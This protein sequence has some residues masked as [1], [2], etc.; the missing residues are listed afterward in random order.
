MIPE[1]L[2][3]TYGSGEFPMF[4]PVLEKLNPRWIHWL[5]KTRDFWSQCDEKSQGTSGKNRIRPERFLDVE[6]PLPPLEEQ[7]RILGRI[8]ELAGSLAEARGLREE[9]IRA[10]DDI[11]SSA[12]IE[13]FTIKSPNQSTVK[14]QNICTVVR[15]GSPRPAGSSLYYGGDIPFI[16]VGDL[17]KDNEKYL[18]SASSSVNEEGKKCSRFIS[19]GTLM[20]TNSGATLGVPKITKIS[21][22]FNDGSQA[23][24][25]LCESVNIE[26]LYY[27]LL[28]KTSWFREQL[29]RGQG[30][31][32][33]NTDMIKCLDVPCLRIEDQNHIVEFL[34]S[35]R[36][37][38][39]SLKQL[40]SETSAEL[41]A[42]LPSILDKA[43]KGEL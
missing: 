43:F 1:S 42:L 28:S 31:P 5:T 32:N 19:E 39:E 11:F 2:A 3:G 37:Q 8:E 22:C 40:Q 12:L 7:R 33:L 36:S 24:L 29:A 6:I 23:F 34:D 15:G 38:I 18:Y 30:Q 27:F 13:A 41:D 25:D 10:L 9:S 26:Y 16:K 20:L 21:G 35:L 14:M 4:T 17:T